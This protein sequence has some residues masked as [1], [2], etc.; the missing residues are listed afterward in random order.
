MIKQTNFTPS[1]PIRIR[2]PVGALLDIP[3]GTFIKGFHNESILLGGLGMLTGIVGR[4]NRFKSTVMHYLTQSAAARVSTTS[5]TSI[6]TYDTEMNMQ[7]PRLNAMAQAFE[8]FKGRDLFD[9][10]FWVLTDKTV[11]SGDKWY[12]D[13]KAYIDKKI[14]HKKDIMVSTPFCSRD[15]VSPLMI[16]SPT[17]GQC[18]SFTAFSTSDVEKIQDENALGESG[19]NMIHARQGLAKMRFMMEVPTMSGSAMHYML[20][21]AHVGQET[22]LAASPYAPVPAKKMQHM[23]Q[24]EKIKGVT[25]QFL[26]LMSDCWHTVSTSLLI[27]KDKA[28]E[29]PRDSDDKTKGDTDLQEVILQQ[30][31]GKAGQSGITIPIVVSQ[32]EGVLPSL[33]EFHFI[34]GSDRFGLGGNMQNYYLELLP[35]VKLSRSVVRRKIDNDPKLRRALNI[36]AEL[37]QLEQYHRPLAP[38]LCSAKE[39]YDDLK[40][41]GY[42][43]DILLNTRGWWTVNDDKNPV[44]RLSTMDLLRMRLDPSDPEHY[45][46][47]WYPTQLEELKAQA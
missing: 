19:G 22:Q 28:P 4:P 31:R 36:T 30:L 2:F 3:T 17:F 14:E 33:T 8:V 43:W 44:P 11:C 29:Y 16:I 12:D 46:P 41:K 27:D 37:C 20:L 34:K 42:D 47:W 23:K 38:M 13:L 35:E 7:E 45:H 24:G 25:D 39:L 18:D 9:E 21:T 10:Q 6:G 40:K 5:E 32:T 26:F 15:K 1:S